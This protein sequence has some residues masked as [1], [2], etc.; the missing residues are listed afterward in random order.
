MDIIDCRNDSRD[1]VG[2]LLFR[3]DELGH[4]AHRRGCL[5]TPTLCPLRSTDRPHVA[6]LRRMIERKLHHS[7]YISNRVLRLQF[8]DLACIHSQ[9]LEY[10]SH[11]R[12]IL[13]LIANLETKS[14]F[15][16]KEKRKK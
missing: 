11:M 9:E 1:S 15:D 10:C 4:G 3:I 14:V 13:A 6:P 12:A 5:G 8:V 16:N 2:L 7:L